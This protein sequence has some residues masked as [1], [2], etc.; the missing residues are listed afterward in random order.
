MCRRQS[1]RLKSL[2]AAADVSAVAAEML[3]DAED[4]PR[5][6]DDDTDHFDMTVL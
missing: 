5:K 6:Q 1:S 2:R 3:C 4:K